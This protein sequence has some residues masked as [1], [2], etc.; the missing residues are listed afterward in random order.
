[1]RA[2]KSK[3]VQLFASGCGRDSLLGNAAAALRCGCDKVPLG[4]L[5][6][7]TA[8]QQHCLSVCHGGAVEVDHVQ[9]LASSKVVQAEPALRT[10]S[11][12]V[13]APNMGTVF[14]TFLFFIHKK[15]P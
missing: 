13:R 15:I 3:K 12:S 6:A 8:G 11:A 2:Q 14:L 1:M 10:G 7:S 5:R 9:G 4:R